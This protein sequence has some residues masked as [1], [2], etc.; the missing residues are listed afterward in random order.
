MENRG[1]PLV[2]VIL[3]QHFDFIG[4]TSNKTSFLND[5]DNEFV[6]PNERLFQQTK[7]LYQHTLDC[8]T[9][10]VA[11]KCRICVYISPKMLNL[12]LYIDHQDEKSPKIGITQPSP[13]PKK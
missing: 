1:P 11:N 12:G 8:G 7:E 3:S 10:V 13:P 6:F 9:Q 2:Y 5:A 4:S